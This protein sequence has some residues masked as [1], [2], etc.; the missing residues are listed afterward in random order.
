[1]GRWTAAVTYPLPILYA[2]VAPVIDV[3]LYVD[4]LGRLVWAAVMWF[5]LLFML[6]WMLRGRA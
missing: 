6:V 3:D 2:T 4:L 1:M 5:S